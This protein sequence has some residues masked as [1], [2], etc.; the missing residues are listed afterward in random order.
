MMVMGR[1]MMMVTMAMMM[2]MMAFGHD[3]DYH[4]F[5]FVNCATSQL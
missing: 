1:M 5:R 3:I 2:M 4:L